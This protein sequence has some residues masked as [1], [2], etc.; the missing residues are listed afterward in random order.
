[1]NPQTAGLESPDLAERLNTSCQCVS[2]DR[3]A[4]R[5]ELAHAPD[6]V[7]LAGMIESDRPHLFSG[8]VVFVSGENIKR[9]AEIIAAVES[10]VAL[11]AYI[12]HVMAY[13]PVNGRHVPRAR[14]VFLGY[15]F[16][17]HRIMQCRRN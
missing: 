17:W 14:G 2:L 8:S 16:M 12:A 5:R 3:A 6:G 13:A 1:M 7:A 9:M 11:P 4:L 10:V 15:D